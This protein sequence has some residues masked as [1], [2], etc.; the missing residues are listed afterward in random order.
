MEQREQIDPRL[1]EQAEKYIEPIRAAMLFTYEQNNPPDGW[2]QEE[3]AE[4]AERA[5]RLV[6]AASQHTTH[7]FRIKVIVPDHIYTETSRNF[8]T[9][10]TDVK[11]FVASD[12]WE[13]DEHKT[14]FYDAVDVKW[15]VIAGHEAELLPHIR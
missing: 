12:I 9:L 2:N 7:R 13:I 1:I 14:V 10:E 15:L 4:R 5:R 6:T 3:L 8:Q 11:D